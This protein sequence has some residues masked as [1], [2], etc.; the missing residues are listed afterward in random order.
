MYIGKSLR[1]LPA[2]LQAVVCDAGGEVDAAVEG[3]RIHVIQRLGHRGLLGRAGLFDGVLKYQARGVAAGGVVA[4]AGVVLG[5]EGLGE[6]GRGRAEVRLVGHRGFPLRRHGHAVRGLA[7]VGELRDVRGDQQRDHAQIDLLVVELA[8]QGAAVG[9]VTAADQ[10]G[11]AGGDDLVDDRSE[12]G[13]VGS[14][15]LVEHDVQAHAL[16][17][18]SGALGD[19]GGEAVVGVDQRDLGVRV[20]GL[21]RVQRALEVLVG[22]GVELEQVLVAELVG[23]TLG[24]AGGDHDLA[25]LLGDHGRSGGQA[26]GIGAEQEVGVVLQDQAAVELLHAAGGGL[27][28]VVLEGDLVVVVADLDAACGVDLIAP[29]LETEQLG[30]GV[31]VELAG[32]RSGEA[33]GDGLGL[34][35]AESGQDEARGD[36]G[37]HGELTHCWISSH[38]YCLCYC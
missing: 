16:G 27:V 21:D 12:V 22:R 24:G 37:A 25:E 31:G 26:G 8:G 23:L 3:H 17:G 4:R 14:V 15:G 30:L 11:G 2:D 9:V 34:G 38:A 29:Q 5:L 10:H 32:F 13:G 28:V 33:D 20:L 36:Q 7:Q 35:V 6:A 18:R 1:E 19:G